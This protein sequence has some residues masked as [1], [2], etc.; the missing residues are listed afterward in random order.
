[1]KSI[2]RTLAQAALAFS[3]ALLVSACG[4][5]GG[6]AA[7]SGTVSLDVTD[8]P[9]LDY[10]HVYITVT[11]VGFHTDANADGTSTGWQ[12]IT[13]AAPVTV[14][15]AQLAN[16]AMYADTNGGAALFSNFTLP[17]G[18]Y[19]QIRIY[20]ASTEDALTTSAGALGLTYNNEVQLTGD[21]A[22]YALRIPTPDGGIRLIPESPV[23]VTDGGNVKLA[24]DF[25]LNNDVV[26]VAPNGATEFILKPRLG[27]FDMNAVGAITGSVSFGNLSTSRIVV[28]AEQVKDP[29]D[30]A[31]ASGTNYR[32]VRR[33]TGVD[34]TT[35]AFT[36]YPLPVFGNATTATYDILV[37]GR[38]VQTAI[39]KGITVH[40]G[41]TPATGVNLGTI[42]L[43][44]GNEYTAQL[45]TAMH[46]S[47]AWMSFYQTVTGDAVPF[48]VRYRHLNPYTGLLWRSIELSS[49]PI[50]VYTYDAAS[51]SIGAAT[52]SP[53][54]GAFTA[55]ADAADFY[56]RG[57]AM[58][59]AGT[60]GQAVGMVNAAANAPAVAAPA[61]ANSI[62]TIFDMTRMGQGMGFGMGRGMA[63]ILKPT[64]GQLFVTH[65]G[66]IIDSL[67]TL[68]GDT[69]VGAAMNAGGGAGHP[70]VMA[71]LPGGS[72][73]QSLPGAF[74]G[75]YGLGWGS[76]VIAAGSTHGIDLRNGSA[77]ATVVMR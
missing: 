26:E 54:N 31:N 55:V 74:Y 47:G 51:G 49:D 30:P 64:K 48:E 28:K 65:G 2:F 40:K 45:T 27:Y 37:R 34:K 21:T 29:S 20:L 69:T 42:T 43:N 17:V 22:H 57:T 75:V 15:L 35:G 76:G 25:N 41:A 67:G 72:A 77:T 39:V 11:R 14:D 4:G 8:A 38:G 13:L 71:N 18:T 63:G 10:T 46:P 5:S 33:W 7:P 23:V 70:V 53:A 58:A 60:A 56:G 44:A 59:L 66:M 32:I 36:L 1:M 73:G 3:L 9:S 52:A 6:S 19:R 68:T 16:G 62:T 24:L 50:Q 12:T 61:T